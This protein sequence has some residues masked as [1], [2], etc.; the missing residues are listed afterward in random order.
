M[1]TLVLPARVEQQDVHPTADR[2]LA[3]IPMPIVR[4]AT[5]AIPPVV[6]ESVQ[7]VSCL[8]V[9]MIAFGEVRHGTLRTIPGN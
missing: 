1:G 9:L 6:K 2:G 5:A 4:I 3:P 7:T 8:N